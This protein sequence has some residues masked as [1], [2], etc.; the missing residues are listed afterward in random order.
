MGILRNKLKK[1][2]VKKRNLKDLITS[3]LE[4]KHYA[5]VPELM[6]LLEEQGR[7]FNKS[8]VYR[9]IEKMV[10]DQQ[11]CR[12]SFG[13]DKVYY[14]LRH[15]DHHHHDHFVCQQ[16]DKIQTFECQLDLSKMPKGYTAEHHHVTI[17]GLCDACARHATP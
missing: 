17:F 8:S 10:E 2:V 16:C 14:E 13:T 7:S 11:V 9:S 15:S 3:I 12:H 6:T 4:E 1:T 5:G